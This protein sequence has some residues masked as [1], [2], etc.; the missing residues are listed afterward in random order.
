MKNKLFLIFFLCIF[1]ACNKNQNLAANENKS[2]TQDEMISNEDFGELERLKPL[3]E[4]KIGTER[5]QVKEILNGYNLNDEDEDSIS[6]KL[7]KI[8]DDLET[9]E[10]DIELELFCDFDE[11]NLLKNF[12]L[13]ME[14]TIP[15]EVE[16]K[17]TYHN[18]HKLKRFIS[19]YYKTPAAS[20]EQGEIDKLKVPTIDLWQTKNEKVLLSIFTMDMFGYQFTV[21]TI[22]KKGI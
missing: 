5:N 7:F 2:F 9:G 11:N 17:I 3:L 13:S 21:Y 4:I 8:Y 6:Y 10:D 22:C 16:A 15:T 20:F 18:Y 14:H 1:T 12:D 19:K